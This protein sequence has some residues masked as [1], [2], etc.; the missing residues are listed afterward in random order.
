MKWLDRIPFSTLIIISLML[1][2]SPFV[3]EPHLLEKLK[4]LTP[5]KFAEQWTLLGDILM[6]FEEAKIVN[7][8]IMDA[9]KRFLISAGL[10]SDAAP[11]L[12]FGDPNIRPFEKASEIW[13]L[14]FL[15]HASYL[16]FH[17]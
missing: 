14:L 8:P 6:S 3:P 11:F 1:G 15:I 10:P 5:E 17:S 13:Q 4:M 7:L 16:S 9:D 12:A 2:L